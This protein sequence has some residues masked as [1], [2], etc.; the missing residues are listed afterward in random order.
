MTGSLGGAYFLIPPPL[1][2]SFL[3][4][5]AGR[6]GHT[7]C[8]SCALWAAEHSNSLVLIAVLHVLVGRPTQYN[9]VER[10]AGCKTALRSIVAG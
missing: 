5:S 6:H 1:M 2:P 10:W 9:Q 7:R 4:F 8:N 3:P